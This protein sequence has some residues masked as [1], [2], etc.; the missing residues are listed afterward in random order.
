[1]C[2]YQTVDLYVCNLN[3]NLFQNVPNYEAV[4]SYFNSYFHKCGM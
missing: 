4:G 1:M 3:R 2:D